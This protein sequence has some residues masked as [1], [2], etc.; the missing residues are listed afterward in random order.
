M[1]SQRKASLL[2]TRPEAEASGLYED[3]QVLLSCWAG[4][5]SLLFPDQD[6]VGEEH[7]K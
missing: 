2:G 6:L 5:I 4:R 3:K 1:V 7:D